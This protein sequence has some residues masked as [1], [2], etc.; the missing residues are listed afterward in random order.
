MHLKNTD[1]SID[2]VLPIHKPLGMTS[3]DVSRW[4]MKR[5]GKVK[6]GHAG[7]LDPGASGVLPIL[8]GQ[9]TKLQD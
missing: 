5:I 8:L 2:G 4:L 7:T 1:F 3:K 6:M 9:A